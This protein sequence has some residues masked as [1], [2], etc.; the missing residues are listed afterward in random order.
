MFSN[1]NFGNRTAGAWKY[2][3][4]LVNLHKHRRWMINLICKALQVHGKLGQAQKVLCNCVNKKA[5]HVL[6]KL[7]KPHQELGKFVKTAGAFVHF[8]N[9]SRCLEH[10]WNNTQQVLCKLAEAQ[11]VLCEFVSVPGKHA[12]AQ[13]GLDIFDSHITEG[14][15]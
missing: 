13:H 6:D 3:K 10:V 8:G 5:Q 14:D 1:C 15:W 11:S 4:C 2:S 7:G 12:K 9:P